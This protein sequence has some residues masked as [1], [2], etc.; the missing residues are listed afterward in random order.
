MKI[1]RVAIVAKQRSYGKNPTNF[2]FMPD[3]IAE[4]TTQLLTCKNKS[5]H[6]AIQILQVFQGG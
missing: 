3:G 4:L 1:F 2:V 6:E 5:L